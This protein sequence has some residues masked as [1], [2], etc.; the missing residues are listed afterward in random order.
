MEQTAQSGAAVIVGPLLRDDVKAL[1]TSGLRLPP[2]VAL[3]AVDETVPLPATMYT[4]ALSVEGEARQIARRVHASGAQRVAI[5]TSDSPL[6]RRFA[7]SFT[8][9]W[10]LL[11]GG[12][13]SSFRF[14]RDPDSLAILRR[15]LARE[16]ADAIVLAAGGI[17]AASVKPYLDQTP[18][19]ASSQVIDRVAPE[20]T[21]DLDDIRF[22]ELPW[23]AQP[24]SDRF[25]DLPRRDWSDVTLD[26]LYALGHDAFHVA[27]ALASGKTSGFE[28]DGATGRL[29]LEPDRQIAREG[30]LMRIENGQ[31][32][33]EAP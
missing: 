16:G 11:G 10:I 30:V 28:L 21:R 1:S 5:V 23:L 22:V 31:P 8:G 33:P 24:E 15:E 26:R 4:L 25:P 27:S 19:Y 6:Q 29:T 2:T 13:P 7:A 9:E 17:D 12:P 14:V 18:V 20:M 32:V 3:N